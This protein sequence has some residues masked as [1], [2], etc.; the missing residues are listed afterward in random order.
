MSPIDQPPRLY[1]ARPHSVT[2]HPASPAGTISP[3]NTDN[4][5][6]P[7]LHSEWYSISPATL[8]AIADCKSQ[9]GR[10][11]AVGTTSL[12][13]L[14]SA[15]ARAEQGLPL[16]GHWETSLFVTPGYRFRMVDALL[17]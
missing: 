12:R 16:H 15:A 6:E 4:I 2:V 3:V 13:T 10:V 11:V 5:A 1:A 8:Q 14:E 7:R 17:T 9:G